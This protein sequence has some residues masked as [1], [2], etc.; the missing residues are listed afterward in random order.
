MPGGVGEF[1]RGMIM[2]YDFVEPGGWGTVTE[3]A[4]VVRV[5][6]EWIEVAWP[7]GSRARF[8]VCDQSYGPLSALT[9]KG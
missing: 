7:T 9:I 6:P 8:G 2:G 4:V 1:E 3:Y 5:G